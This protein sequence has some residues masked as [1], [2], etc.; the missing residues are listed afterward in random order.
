V[1]TGPLVS[2]VIPTR[3]RPELVRRALASAVAQDYSG[4]LE[5]F[6]VHDQEQPDASLEEL[7]APGRSVRVLVSDA[8]PGLAGA[9]NAGR[10]Q[11]RGP[12]IASLDDDDVWHPDKLRRQVEWLDQ[13]PDVDVVGTGIRLMM[14][15]GRVF[16]WPGQATFVGRAD[17]L[18]GRIKELHSSTLLCRRGVYDRVGGY[19]EELPFGYGEDYDWLLRA[20]EVGVLGVVPQPLADISKIGQSWFR[21]RQENVA[22]GLEYLYAKHSAFG[23][24]RRG[25]ARVLGQIA[26]AHASAGNRS[27]A[28]KWVARSLRRWPVDP[29]TLLTVVNLTTGLDP[30]A[31][32]RLA[33]ACG[34]GVS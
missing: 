15:E 16:D 8:R 10:K 9:R 11:T 33:R 30:Q 22:Q 4:P 32:L 21:E 6:V 24:T 25:E 14:P 20:A 27:G 12:L 3:G 23:E 7:A 2:V 18:R 19:D 28:R 26:F 17:L 13:H 29:H 1:S 31:V 5:C 34:R